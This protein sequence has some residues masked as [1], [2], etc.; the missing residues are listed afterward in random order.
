MA[1]GGKRKTLKKKGMK[2]VKAQPATIPELRAAFEAVESKAE[3]LRGANKTTQIKEFQK[4]WKSVFGRDI[5]A[6]AVDAYLHVKLGAKKQRMT[7]KKGKSQSGGAMP[8]D[9]AP[10]DYQTRP[11]IDGVHAT[12]PAYVQQGLGFYDS[13]NQIGM[14]AECGVKDITPQIPKGMGS[15][16][17]GGAASFADVASAISSK[18]FQSTIPS[19]LYQDMRTAYLG[20]PL[21]P[22]PAVEDSVWKFK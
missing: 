17:A 22:S 3:A 2:P 14:K 6:K 13:I 20:Q 12:Y 5:S 21:P 7:R 18:P 9:G 15:N 16:Q 4:T 1:V 10:L 19:T 11:G 8:L